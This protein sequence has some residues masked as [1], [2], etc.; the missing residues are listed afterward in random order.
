[1][2]G[3]NNKLANEWIDW[4]ETPDPQG[5]REKEIIPFV[6]KWLKDLRPRIVCDIG[7]GQGICSELVDSET[8]YIGIDPSLTLLERARNLYP[9]T[10]KRFIEGNAYDIPQ[11]KESADAVI[12]IWV[13]SH[14]EKPGL[15]AKEMFRI[16]KSKG[17]FLIVTANPETY[18]ERKTF[19]T[20][21][22]IEGNLL[23]GSFD[24]GNGKALTGTTLYLH[25]KQE[26][27]DA[28][29]QA[30]FKIN[31]VKRMGQA[32]SSDK[33]LYLVVEGSR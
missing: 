17:R 10:N 16:L 13:W 33:G 32:E 30:G 22:T 4:V 21:Y 11:E 5:A 2:S 20:H 3:Y 6:Q 28:I 12:S 7:C 25:T 27:E 19:Y 1:M 15:A 8:E 29:K 18:E 24:L 23:K 26:I 14:L 31:Y 9:V